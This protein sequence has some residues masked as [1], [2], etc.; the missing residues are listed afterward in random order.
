MI[1]RTGC[2]FHDTD[3]DDACWEQSFEWR[4]P[5]ATPAGF[6]AARVFTSEGEEDMVPF[7]VSSTPGETGNTLCFLAPT[8]SYL[9]Y[10]NQ[11]FVRDALSI[12]V[13]AR[14]ESE[15]HSHRRTATRT[16]RTRGWRACRPRMRR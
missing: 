3:L 6:Y 13:H 15:K 2:H 7:I 10:S 16:A 1:V 8:V 14:P 9:A 12:C 11:I 5:Q 4:I